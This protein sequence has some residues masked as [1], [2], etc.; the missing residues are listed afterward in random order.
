M[1]LRTAIQRVGSSTYGVRTFT[2][3]TPILFPRR[4]TNQ[5]SPFYQPDYGSYESTP[6]SPA[7]ASSSKPPPSS[8]SDSPSISK[9]RTASLPEQT[10]EDA[11]YDTATA[12]E[13]ARRNA[14]YL[15]DPSEE[16]IDPDLP[17]RR[18][19]HFV[20]YDPERTTP[21]IDKFEVE[22]IPHYAPEALKKLHGWMTSEDAAFVL[23]TSS[24]RF[25]HTGRASRENLGSGDVIDVYGG[26]VEAQWKWIVVALAKGRGKGIV[27]RAERALRIW[28]SRKLAVHEVRADG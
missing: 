17:I 19:P 10:F 8:S 5:F 3:S 4:T 9:G 6:D 22:S 11:D 20:T 21:Q 14:W 15:D 12:L 23:D 1:S 13:S 24:V 27:G 18:Q 28:V 2:S 7:A 26:E 25:L 16:I